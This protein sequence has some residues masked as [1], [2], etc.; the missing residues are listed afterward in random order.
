[1]KIEEE[2]KKKEIEK[3]KRRSIRLDEIQE[4]LFDMQHIDS[5][6][7]A[8]SDETPHRKMLTNKSQT[9]DISEIMD[10]EKLR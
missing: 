8:I 2:K 10:D 3:M 7:S 5:S 6:I 1:M 4:G 9:S